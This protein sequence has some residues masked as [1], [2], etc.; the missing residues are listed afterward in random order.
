MNE[1]MEQ[2]ED[3]D[4]STFN[5]AMPGKSRLNVFKNIPLDDSEEK[6]PKGFWQQKR[7]QK[8]AKITQK[9]Q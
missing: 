7:N 1:R 6:Q 8:K 2:V 9:Y 4:I 3:P 5:I